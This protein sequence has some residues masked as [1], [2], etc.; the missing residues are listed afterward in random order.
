M[1]EKQTRED[2]A[3]KVADEGLGYY[4]MDYTSADEMPDEE[5]KLAFQVAQDAL[6]HFESLLPDVEC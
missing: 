6:N 3:Y 1:S 5:L 4:I 2:V